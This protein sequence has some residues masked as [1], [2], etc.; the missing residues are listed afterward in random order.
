MRS[1]VIG[2]AGH[3]DHGKSA[4]IKALTGT[5]PDRLVEEKERG[6]T[7]DLGFAHLALADDLQASIVDVPGHERFVKNMVAG[8]GG[9][10][11][12]LMVIAADEGVMPQTREHLDICGL[13]GIKQGVV[14]LNKTDLIEDPEWIDLVTEDVRREFE[15]TFLENSPIVPVSS[16]SGDG[17]EALQK[18]LA[19]CGRELTVKGADGLAFLAVDRAF[20]MRGFGTVVTGTLVSGRL[21]LE[22]GVDVL[23]DA[24]GKLTELKIRGLQS[25]GAELKQA[26][27]GQRLAINLS[28]VEKA[29]MHRGQVL[30][31][32]GS[33]ELGTAFEASLR[34]LPG[35]KPLRNRK[36]MLFHTGTTKVSASLQLIGHRQLEPGASSWVR[37]HCR[38]PVAALPGQ[39]FILRGF[40]PIPGRGTTLGGGRILSIL[41]P[42]RREKDIDHW[43]TEL[44]ILETGDLAERLSL[45]L[46]RAGIRGA[47]LAGLALRSGAGKRTVERE[48]SKLLAN[49][50]AHKFDKEGGRYAAAS[51]LTG[52][53]ERARTL[54]V[55]FHEANP[56]L[57]GMP[58]EQ[59]RGSLATELEP[60][61]FRLLLAEL[62]RSEQIV[63]DKEHTRLTSHRVQLDAAGTALEKAILDLYRRA[64]LSPP[65]LA[66]AATQLEKSEPDLRD[67]LSHL[68]RIG[69]LTHLT[70]NMFISSEA[71]DDLEQRLIAHLEEH[72]SIDTQTFKR[73]VGASRKH[74][75][76][77][78]EF[79]DRKKTTIRVGD[80]RVLRGRSKSRGG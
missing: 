68:A 75:I 24:T 73:M 70:G 67:L 36:R 78:A 72:E 62:E 16:K 31:H 29:S 61:L 32:T 74:V 33:L 63:V 80:K 47:D 76:P 59:L 9:I 5:D 38:E 39:Y 54:L 64:R 71:L 48:L 15:G 43:R 11:L 25:H 60:K 45:L 77:L 1:F 28:G 66:E 21:H 69:S 56:L 40:S 12:V 26:A 52:L 46:E 79:F 20:T 51:V 22:D 50:S 35:A 37:V 6:I 2:T 44:T 10:D 4:L 58:T 3:I 13:L 41:P 14:A 19:D 18:V 65:R 23:P 30:V 34:L 57:P 17:L 7:I 53:A 42:R 8:T 55:A 27:A 49:R